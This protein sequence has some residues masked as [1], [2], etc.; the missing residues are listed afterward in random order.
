MKTYTP[1]PPRA[2]RVPTRPAGPIYAPATRIPTADEVDEVMEQAFRAPSL[3]EFVM[4]F[5][6]GFRGCDEAEQKAVMAAW[7][8]RYEAALREEAKSA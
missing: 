8:E 2:L 5:K 6:V 7:V 1:P 3:R 4:A